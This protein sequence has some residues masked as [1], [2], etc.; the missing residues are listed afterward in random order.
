[1][2]QGSTGHYNKSSGEWDGIIGAL[3]NG[4]ADCTGGVYFINEERLTAVE[5]S[6]PINEYKVIR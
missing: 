1:M 5:Y 3:V 4:E 6:Y 2:P